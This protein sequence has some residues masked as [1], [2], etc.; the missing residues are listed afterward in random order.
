VASPTAARPA[1]STEGTGPGP[2]PARN[3]RAGLD[4][5]KASLADPDAVVAAGTGQAVLRDIER[6]MPRLTNSTDS[7]EATYY[8]VEANLMLERPAEACRL[9]FRVRERAR[10]TLFEGRIERF[11]GDADLACANR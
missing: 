3:G 11:L 8:A 1:R 7:V 6:L 10:N 9:L 5:I 4:R 2:G